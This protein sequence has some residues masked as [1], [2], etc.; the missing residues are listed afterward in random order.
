MRSAQKVGF[1]APE[2]V[3]RWE[4]LFDEVAASG[5]FLWQVTYIL[6]SG[7]KMP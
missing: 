4:T 2:E 6:R 5:S 3:P 7:M 1:L